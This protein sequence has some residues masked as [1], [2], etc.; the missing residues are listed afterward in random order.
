[1][2][3]RSILARTQTGAHGAF[4][5]RPASRRAINGYSGWLPPLA[6]LWAILSLGAIYLR[7]PWPPDE[8]RYLA[9]AWEMWVRGDYLVP[10]LNGAPYSDKPPLLFWII[11]LGWAVFGVSEWWPR[12]VPP[13][14]ALGSVA[15]SAQLARRLWPQQREIATTACWILFGTLFWAAFMTFVFFDMLVVGFTLLALLGLLAAARGDTAHGFAGF[16][17]ALALGLLAKGPFVLICTLP[18]ALAARWWMPHKPR[19]DWYVG[20]GLAMLG[21]GAA[22]LVWAGWAA[23]AGGPAYRD[24]IFWRQTAGRAVASFSHARA[25]W[26]YLALLPVLLFPWTIWPTVWAALRRVPVNAGVRLLL[27]WIVPPFV[28]LSLLSGKQP[29][30]LLPL[31][32]GFALLAAFSLHAHSPHVG[33]RHMLP[34]AVAILA[35]AVVSAIAAFKGFTVPLAPPLPWLPALLLAAIGIAL[36][37][38]PR[39]P[40][41]GAR[42]L[43]LATVAVVATLLATTART[44]EPTNDLRPVATYLAGLE[45]SGAAIGHVGSYHGELHFLGRLRHPIDVLKENEIESWIAVHPDAHII[46]YAPEAVEPYRSPAQGFTAQSPEFAQPYRSGVLLVWNTRVQRT[47]GPR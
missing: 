21:G 9:V 42:R 20:V 34:P 25:W 40:V 38:P 47:D 4:R 44:L 6:I 45:R 29:H 22:A 11:H 27:A 43:A 35:L 24:A 37:V 17:A 5:A 41:H 8:T 12:L 39:D 19:R 28:V 31:F 13:L 3:V 14:F 7:A 10:Y 16:G 2:A 36:L 15:L 26:W 32:P 18:V 1:M 46:S 30:Y 33:T 23:W